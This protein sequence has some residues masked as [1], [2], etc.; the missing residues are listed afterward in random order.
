MEENKIQQNDDLITLIIKLW[1]G[2]SFILKCGVI[3]GVLG[4]IIAMSIPKTYT[5]S[6][7]VAPELEQQMGSSLG[8]IAS[9]VGASLDNS[10]DAINF[11]MLTNVL[12]SSPFVL[13]LLNDQV[14]TS[15]GGQSMTLMDYLI[16]HQRKPWWSHVIAAPF[17]LLGW[18]MNLGSDEEDQDDGILDVANLPN[19][20]REVIREFPSKVTVKEDSKTGLITLSVTMQ[21]P[22]VA[23][24]V[25]NSVLTNL[26][27]FMSDYRTKKDRQDVENLKVIYDERKADYYAAQK[28]YADFVDANKNLVLLSAQSEQLKLQQEMNLA[29]QVYSQVATQLEAARIKEQQ[30]KPVLVILEPVSVPNRKSAPSKA[31]YLMAF[32]FLG[33]CGAGAWL[34][35]GKEYCEKFKNAL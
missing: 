6:V 35:F 31:K 34:L 1:K 28:A 7:T 20:V 2:R 32:M 10:I 9:M 22:K 11:D 25:M 26:I 18:L 27:D 29:Y 16:E 4:I 17:D 23:A 24:D 5:S 8:A 30:S 12:Q 19:R 15:E 3:G 21:D 13:N 33:A 14:E